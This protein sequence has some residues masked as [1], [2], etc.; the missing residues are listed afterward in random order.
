MLLSYKMFTFT[1]LD[2]FLEDFF[3]RRMYYYYHLYSGRKVGYSERKPQAPDPDSQS[4][5]M[6]PHSLFQKVTKG[7]VTKGVFWSPVISALPL[8]IHTLNLIQIHTEP[9]VLWTLTGKRVSMTKC[10]HFQIISIEHST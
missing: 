7:T 9:A 2:A 3:P 5:S 6:H 8:C 4:Q 1:L 10:Y